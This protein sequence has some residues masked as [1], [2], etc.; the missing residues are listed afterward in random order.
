MYNPIK[1]RY[2]EEKNPI[3]QLSNERKLQNNNLIEKLLLTMAIINLEWFTLKDR[4][5]IYIRILVELYNQKN[6][7]SVNEIY[8]I[9]ELEKMYTTITKNLCNHGAH[10]IIKILQIQDNT[11]MVYSNKDKFVF[12]IINYINCNKYN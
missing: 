12:Y 6:Q 1:T 2:K 8:E 11:Y 9:I 10:Q 4:L 5:F 7:K 3:N